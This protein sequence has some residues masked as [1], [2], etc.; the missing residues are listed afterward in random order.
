MRIF[1]VDWAIGFQMI[2][3]KELVE[4]PI[5]TLVLKEVFLDQV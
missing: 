4:V 2:S 1:R 5:Q 3:N